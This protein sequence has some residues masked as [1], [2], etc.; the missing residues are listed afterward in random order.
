ML[1]DAA[2]RSP[3]GVAGFGVITGRQDRDP[4]GLV[5]LHAPLQV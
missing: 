1:G 5:L 2:Q 4:L 3:R